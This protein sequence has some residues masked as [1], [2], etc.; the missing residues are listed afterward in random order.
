MIE[1]NFVS[2]FIKLII[3]Y[4]YNIYILYIIYYNLYYIIQYS[5]WDYAFEWNFISYIFFFS[6]KDKFYQNNFNLIY[7][8]IFNI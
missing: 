6:Y 5:W 3:Q 1:F 7:K 4:Y 8:D 2:I